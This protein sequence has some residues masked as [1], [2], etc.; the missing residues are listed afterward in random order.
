VAEVGGGSAGGVVG[1]V[2]RDRHRERRRCS[3]SARS[4]AV[5]RG[6]TSVQRLAQATVHN[7]TNG[8]TFA[9]AQCIP[10]PLSRTSTTTLFALSVLPLPIG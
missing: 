3:G 7:A 10:L 8:L 9:R 1:I 6:H 5:M 4:R 2:W